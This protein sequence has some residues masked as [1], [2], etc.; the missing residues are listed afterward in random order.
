[1]PK[2]KK[3][4]KAVVE[5]AAAGEPAENTAPVSGWCL[6]GDDGEGN[7]QDRELEGEI[8]QSIIDARNMFDPDGE[9]VGA[10]D[11][12]LVHVA[13]A[14]PPLRHAVCNCLVRGR[15]ASAA[16]HRTAD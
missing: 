11:P 4:G 8:K 1:M 7:D 15:R 14:P 3:K 5:G 9:G 13:C 2:K 10:H 6:L 16:A 12:G